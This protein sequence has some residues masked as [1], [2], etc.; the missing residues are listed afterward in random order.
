MSNEILLDIDPGIFIPKYPDFNNMY[1]EDVD[2]ESYDTDDFYKNIY[3]KR[4]FREVKLD[5]EE[6]V[7]KLPG[8][9]MNHQKFLSR[10]L[11]HRTPYD[12]ILLVHAMGVGKTCSSIS[13]I[14]NNKDLYKGAIILAK[15]EGLLKNY[16]NELVF[17]CTPGIYIP[18]N[19]DRLT[20]L[21]KTHRI[22]K[23]TTYYDRQTFEVFA[24]NITNMNDKVIGDK[25]DNR[26]IVIDEIHNIRPNEKEDGIDVYG[27]IHRFLHVVKN[28]K[29]VLMSGTPM[30]DGPEEIASVMNLILP[31]NR[32]LPMG[33]EFLSKYMIKNKEES[34]SMN[35]DFVEEFKNTLKGYVSYL[36]L[37]VRGIEKEFVGERVGTL[38]HFLV[39][40]DTMSEFQTE[41]Y[42]R[43]LNN[44]KT[45]KKGWY[46]ESRQASLFVFPDGSYGPS[47][48]N[49]YVIKKKTASERDA[50]KAVYRYQLSRELQQELQGTNDSERLRK[51]YRFSS[52][53]TKTIM[54][55]ISDQIIGKTS[56]VYN[57]FVEGSGSILFSYIG[58]FRF[59]SGYRKRKGR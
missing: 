15:N 4:E 30:K 26:V 11:S 37:V 7:P 52:K 54:T 56:F 46:N 50:K 31:M 24:K 20:D 40:T 14:E 36:K 10:F 58:T 49:K 23:L 1:G 13:I 19:I 17:K 48:F 6:D 28:C 39:D 8:Q 57:E 38:E 27:Q 29:V 3:N 59:R 22:G 53:Y 51:L 18:E 41:H 5:R 44:D 45:E 32:Q 47:G 34:Y 16:E 35:P 25:Y 9:M 55:I 2:Y 21:E 42:M 43:A 33:D 12:K